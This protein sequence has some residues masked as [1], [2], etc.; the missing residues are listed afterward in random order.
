MA[1]NIGELMSF[2][3]GN[4]SNG[5]TIIILVALGALV[6]AAMILGPCSAPRY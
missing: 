6:L 3:E 4:G 2:N 5:L 1:R